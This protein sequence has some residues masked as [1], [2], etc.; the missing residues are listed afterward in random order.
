MAK[1]APQYS[2]GSRSQPTERLTELRERIQATRR[3]E[4]AVA[5]LQLASGDSKLLSDALEPNALQF[6]EPLTENLME[7]TKNGK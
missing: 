2:L 4:H 6:T 7:E 1:D 3:L 5:V